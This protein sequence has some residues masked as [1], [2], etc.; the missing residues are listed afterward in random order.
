MKRNELCFPLSSVQ[1]TFTEPIII[2]TEK[3]IIRVSYEIREV[4]NFRLY[5][6]NIDVAAQKKYLMPPIFLNEFC[7]DINV[8]NDLKSYAKITMCTSL[9]FKHVHFFKI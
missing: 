9:N 6:K 8:H 2:S 4:N 1:S 7:V 5:N 3:Q